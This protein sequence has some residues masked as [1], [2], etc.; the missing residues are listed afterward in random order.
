MTG[1]PDNWV[2]LLGVKGGAAINPNGSMPT[3]NLLHL[4]GKNIVVDCGLG[5]AAGIVKQGVALKAIDVIFITHMHSDH[6][7]ELGPLLHTAWCSGLNRPVIVY[8]PAGTED[9]WKHFLESMRADIDIRQADEG[10]PDIAQLVEIRQLDDGKV[11]SIGGIFVTAMRNNHPPL[12][13]S[14]ALRFEDGART[15]VFSGDTTC[16]PPLAEFA[17]G[18]DL[19]IHEAMLPEGIER[20]VARVGNGDDRLRKHLYHSHTPAADVGRIAHAAGVKV[21]AVNH[22]VPKDDPAIQP[23]HWR[24]AIA[25]HWTG[26][27]HIGSDGLRI[28]L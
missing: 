25:E 20:L 3:A 23:D 7:L 1:A 4:S 22:L 27:L 13:D 2:A 24:E 9:Y 11:A 21:L 18:A 5:V 16:F 15:I 6:Y 8:G 10:R 17:R 28:P 19:L 12:K 14:F 26:S